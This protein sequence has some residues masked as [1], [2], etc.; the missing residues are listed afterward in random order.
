MQGVEERGERESW[1]E[2]VVVSVQG[3]EG[4]G[5]RGMASSR[6]CTTSRREGDWEETLSKGKS[7]RAIWDPAQW[8][9]MPSIGRDGNYNNN[10]NR[11]QHR[12]GLSLPES[13]HRA[14]YC[15]MS[16]PPMPPDSPIIW[17]YRP[18]TAHAAPQ[19]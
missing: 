15:M 11:K 9:L 16:S 18:S 19:T 4:A 3:R 13:Q 7:K 2:E 14:A 6:T 8:H 5:E 10:N 1:G 12:P 17:S